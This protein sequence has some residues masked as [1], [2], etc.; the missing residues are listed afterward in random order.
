MKQIVVVELPWL[1]SA[2]SI[3]MTVL[4]GNLRKSAW[5]VGLL[6]QLLWFLWIYVT[7]TWG[8]LPLNIMLFIVYVRNYRLWKEN[9]L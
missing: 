2:I 1:L 9:G 8:F 6:N 4:T 5:V 3:W 7:G